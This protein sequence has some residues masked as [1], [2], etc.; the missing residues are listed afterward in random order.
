MKA[1]NIVLTLGLV[2]LVYRLT[3]KLPIVSKIDQS[4]INSKTT[5]ITDCSCGCNKVQNLNNNGINYYQP[6]TVDF[7]QLVPT[8]ESIFIREPLKK[9]TQNQYVC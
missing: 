8:P 2:Y 4:I 3:N 5:N 1:S 9:F 6:Q 7:A